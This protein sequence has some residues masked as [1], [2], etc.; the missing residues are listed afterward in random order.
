MI[1]EHIYDKARY[2]GIEPYD[3]PHGTTIEAI[4]KMVAT[5]EMRDLIRKFVMAEPENAELLNGLNLIQKQ[6]DLVLLVKD[7]GHLTTRMYMGIE[8]C[9]Q[10]ECYNR[11]ERL[12]TLGYLIKERISEK[13]VVEY[14]Y[15]INERI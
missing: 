3:L 6:R 15:L 14:K 9:S 7:H 2:Y 8:G 5:E 10:Q 1:N 12:V 13:R 11:L 4:I